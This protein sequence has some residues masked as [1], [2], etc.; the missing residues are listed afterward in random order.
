MQMQKGLALI[1]IV[2]AVHSEIILMDLPGEVFAFILE[3]LATL[4]HRLT[5]AVNEKVQLG[6]MVSS[7]WMAREKLETA[8]K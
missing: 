1:D 4:E 2:R 7:F 3:E 8:S 6:A 5:G